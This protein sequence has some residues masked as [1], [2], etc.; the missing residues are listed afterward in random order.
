MDLFLKNKWAFISGSTAGIGLAIAKSLAGEGVDI[1][2]NGRTEETVA[3]ARLKLQ[4][5]FPAVEVSGVPCDFSNRSEVEELIEKLSSYQIDILIN[6]VGIYKSQSFYETCDED[7]ARQFEVNLMS[8]V[9]MSRAVLPSMLDRN[10]GRIIFISS[11]CAA[12]VPKDLIAY[13]TTKTALHGLSRGLAQLCRGTDVTVNVVMPGST[14]SEGAEVFLSDVAAKE[15]K[16]KEEVEADFFKNVRT[17]SLLQRFA[18][19]DEV[20][21]TVCYLC[22]PR[23]AATNG[24]AIRVEGGSVGGVI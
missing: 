6:N 3:D 15:Q 17:S 19:V 2:I 1:I 24:A 9:R 21:S 13:S 7:W 16:T 23:A 22:S 11:E 14:L 18:A 20:A 12:I 5:E 10:M 8:G 4:K